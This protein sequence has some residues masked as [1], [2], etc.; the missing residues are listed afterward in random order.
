[1]NTNRK[2]STFTRNTRM[3]TMPMPSVCAGALN[4]ANGS[5]QPPKNSVT[6]NADATNMFAYSPMK[7][8]ANL[9]ELYSML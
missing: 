8:S 4:G 5:D 6:I 1:M 7:N 3:C 9:I 2:T